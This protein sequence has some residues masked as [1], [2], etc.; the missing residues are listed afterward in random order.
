M[1]NLTRVGLYIVCFALSLYGLNA[2]HYEKILKGNHIRQAQVL[3]FLLAMA[4]AYLV[5]E[6]MLGLAL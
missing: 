3:Y 2:V 4:L 6:F 1:G 5:S